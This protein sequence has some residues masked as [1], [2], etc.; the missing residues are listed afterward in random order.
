MRFG[1]L[2]T[3]SV[4][5]LY[6]EHRLTTQPSKALAMLPFRAVAT[7]NM[8]LRRQAPLCLAPQPAKST[9]PSRV[10][11][12]RAVFFDSIYVGV[13]IVA[14]FDGLLESWYSQV[15]GPHRQ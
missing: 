6:P 7:V 15:K 2:S 5:S 9:W 13:R 3:P 4:R 1:R 12:H 11:D 14:L 10:L 8:Y